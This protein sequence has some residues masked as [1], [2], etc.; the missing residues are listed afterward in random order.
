MVAYPLVY[1]RIFPVF[2]K[3]ISLEET[4]DLMEVVSNYFQAH[5]QTTTD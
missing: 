4:N 5:D 2:L 3:S 1:V